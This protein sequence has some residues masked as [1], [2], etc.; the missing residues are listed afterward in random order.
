MLCNRRHDSGQLLLAF[1]TNIS[2]CSLEYSFHT[3]AHQ[4]AQPG[5]NG[6]DVVF[7]SLHRINMY[8]VFDHF[9]DLLPEWILSRCFQR[10]LVIHQEFKYLPELLLHFHECSSSTQPKRKKGVHSGESIDG[11]LILLR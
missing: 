4:P 6:E 9:F 5:S 11:E 10:G 8:E 1:I 3:P 7:K 2:P